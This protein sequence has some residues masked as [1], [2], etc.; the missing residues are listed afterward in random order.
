ML[1]FYGNT[2]TTVTAGRQA[3]SIV[4]PVLTWWNTRGILEDEDLLI[5]VYTVRLASNDTKTINLFVS[6][7][8]L[9]R[10]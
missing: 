10:K 2:L 6:F 3:G 7:S 4:S 8:H 1:L 9:E 5:N